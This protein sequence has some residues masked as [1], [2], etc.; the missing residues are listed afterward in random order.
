[1]SLPAVAITTVS[2]VRH[3]VL[4]LTFAD[5]LPGQAD[6]LAR[7]HGPVVERART[8]EGF[9]EARADLESQTVVWPRRADLAPDTLDER[10]RTGMWP[11]HNV[12]A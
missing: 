1:M 11:D 6:V 9:A 3:G 7:M 12:A 5:G 2:V 10:V 4:A 8:P